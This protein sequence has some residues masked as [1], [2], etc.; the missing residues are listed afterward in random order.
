VLGRF[1]LSA[2]FSRIFIIFS[3]WLLDLSGVQNG[4]LYVG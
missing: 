4:F 3:S 2:V 1:D